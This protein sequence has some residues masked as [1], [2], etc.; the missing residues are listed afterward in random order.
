MRSN[1]PAS[2]PTNQPARPL[3]SFSPALAPHTGRC[4][5]SCMEER[6]SQH[7]AYFATLHN[8]LQDVSDI[9]ASLD[10]LTPDA[11]DL[12]GDVSKFA[13]LNDLVAAVRGCPHCDYSITAAHALFCPR[14]GC[15]LLTNSTARTLPTTTTTSSTATTRCNNDAHNSR[16]RSC[17]KCGSRLSPALAPPL[18]RF[19][20]KA[21]SP[22]E[23]NELS[24][25]QSTNQPTGPAHSISLADGFGGPGTFSCLLSLHWLRQ[26]TIPSLNQSINRSINQ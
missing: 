7:D 2:Q 1:Q 9:C 3:P 16:A 20:H 8:W 10:Q 12:S 5:R 13:D 14:C 23:A 19:D 15:L 17:T 4:P 18:R 21:G 22:S 24:S 6:W 25:K 26:R 11:A